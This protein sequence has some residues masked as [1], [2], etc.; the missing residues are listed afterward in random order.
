MKA[1]LNKHGY[2]YLERAYR[3]KAMLC[4]FVPSNSATTPHDAA[5]LRPTICGDWCPHFGEPEITD[6]GNLVFDVVIP[7]CNGT[8][9]RCDELTDER[10]ESNKQPTDRR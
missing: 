8:T 5:V 4:P 3:L 2:L 10:G 7:I 9:I 1:L 6:K